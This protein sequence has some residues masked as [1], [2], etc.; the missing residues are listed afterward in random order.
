MLLELFR[1]DSF[2]SYY[3]VSVESQLE[4]CLWRGLSEAFQRGSRWL[5]ERLSFRRYKP[6][7]RHQTVYRR[8]PWVASFNW[9]NFEKP[10][11]PALKEQTTDQSKVCGDRGLQVSSEHWLLNPWWLVRLIS[12]FISLYLLGIT[13]FLTNLWNWRLRPTSLESPQWLLMLCPAATAATWRH[14]RW[15]LKVNDERLTSGP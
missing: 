5:L 10:G 2:S 8:R 6:M 15:F 13:E 12:P 7:K 3:P 1:E 4:T 14:H 9:T 11:L